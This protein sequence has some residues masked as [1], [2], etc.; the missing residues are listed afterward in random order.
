MFGILDPACKLSYTVPGYGF[1]QI[2]GAKQ[3]N[4]LTKEHF[5][6]SSEYNSISLTETRYIET[7]KNVTADVMYRY[8]DGSPAILSKAY[9]KGTSILC[10]V[11]M[12]LSYSGRALIGDDFSSSD[13]SGSN[14]S[15]KDFVL[16]ICYDSGIEK[17]ICSA[18]D[19]KISIIKTN[20]ECLIIAIN[21]AQVPK[22]GTVKLSEQYDTVKTVYGNCSPALHPESITFS[23]RAD[24]SCVLR[25]SK[26]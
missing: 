14:K 25:L 5:T 6:I 13:K 18:S 9:G 3:D 19:V 1:D 21:S 22:N 8:E 20:S 26:N 23:L 15:A 10:G 17:N 7:Y 4:L 24:E 16:N 11:D 12:V 2:F